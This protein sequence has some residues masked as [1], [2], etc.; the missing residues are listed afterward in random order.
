MLPAPPVSLA[1]HHVRRQKAPDVAGNY[2]AVLFQGKM[3]RIQE[4]E[5]DGLEVPLVR[6]G[7]FGGED[8]I[9][10]APDH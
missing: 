6:V 8:V 1:R 10:F 5:L 3:P 7:A 2:L 9:V 4:V